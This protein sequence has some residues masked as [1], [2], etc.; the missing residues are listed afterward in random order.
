VRRFV[1][2]GAGG[3]S[4]GRLATG[5]G[6]ERRIGGSVEPNG[7]HRSAVQCRRDGRQAKTLLV[8]SFDTAVMECVRPD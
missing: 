7:W 2:G 4:L 5:R 6:R 3:V 1:L 8:D